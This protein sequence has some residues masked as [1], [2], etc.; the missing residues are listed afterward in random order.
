MRA[1][2]KWLVLWT[3]ILGTLGSATVASACTYEC[4]SIWWQG[5]FVCIDTGRFTGQTCIQTSSCL[6]TTVPIG[7]CSEEASA[8]TV[9]NPTLADLGIVPAELDGGQCPATG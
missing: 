4:R 2:A 1:S 3:L 7:I 5:C 9:E 8:W 6:C